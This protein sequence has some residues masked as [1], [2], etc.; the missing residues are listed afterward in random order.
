MSEIRQVKEIDESLIVV[1]QCKKLLHRP[2][3]SESNLLE[4]IQEAF[5]VVCWL[6]LQDFYAAFHLRRNDRVS[7]SKI[8][9]THA[10]FSFVHLISSADDCVSY[11]YLGGFVEGA[12]GVYV[13]IK[14]D[15]SN[16]DP[17]AKQE[18]VLTAETT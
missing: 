10:D 7:N 6:V 17:H 5:Y 2:K 13:V 1:E 4:G 14:N 11:V 8:R 16:H 12:V 15:D 3:L 9:F 18:C